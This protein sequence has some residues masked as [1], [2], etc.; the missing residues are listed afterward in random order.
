MDVRSKAPTRTTKATRTVAPRKVAASSPLVG[1]VGVPAHKQTQAREP[2]RRVDDGG[3]VRLAGGLAPALLGRA[4]DAAAATLTAVRSRKEPANASELVDAY[5]GIGRSV[6][7]AQAVLLS[8]LD[9]LDAKTGGGV[10][11]PSAPF[12]HLRARAF[13]MLREAGVAFDA[14]EGAF[15]NIVH[16]GNGWARQPVERAADRGDGR[17]LYAYRNTFKKNAPLGDVEQRAE[18]ATRVDNFARSGGKFEDIIVADRATFAEL[19]GYVAYDYVL[20]ESGTL[21]LFATNDLDPNAPKPGHS[22]LAEGSATYTATNALLAGELWVLKDSAGDVEAVLLANNSGHFKPEYRD[23]ANALPHL[24][25]LGIPADKVV[26]FG[27]PNNLPSMF[28][29]IEE[30]CGLA[31]LAARLPT[32]P[33]LLLEELATS[34]KSVLSVRL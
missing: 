13:A 22:L 7:V 19:E 6:A 16:G 25:A 23:L 32:E 14:L 20:V 24:A 1:A 2:T 21:R 26:L 31:G 8:S 33:H 28:A 34:T 3:A 30:R 12:E 5:A 17:P 10:A 15:A 29:E 9:A 11:K 4:L 27:G 18:Y